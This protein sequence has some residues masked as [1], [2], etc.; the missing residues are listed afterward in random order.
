MYVLLMLVGV[1]VKPSSKAVR[2]TSLQAEA[3]AEFERT[4]ASVEPDARRE[5]E[6]A[7][8]IAIRQGEYE[9]GELRVMEQVAEIDDFVIWGHDEVPDRS[10]DSFTKGVEEWI[11]TAT[12]VGLT[13]LEVVVACCANA[14]LDPCDRP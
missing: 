10:E 14:R 4:S 12:A 9:T 1:V 11:A 5:D 7:L 8:Q 2:D 3:V 13:L 6:E